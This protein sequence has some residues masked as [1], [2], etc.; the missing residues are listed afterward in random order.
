MERVDRIAAD[1]DAG[2]RA[3]EDGR[4][5]LSVCYLR[6]D[7]VCPS[8]ALRGR[9]FQ[10]CRAAKSRRIRRA[11]LASVEEQGARLLTQLRALQLQG[12]G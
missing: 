1:V 12:K 5:A 3:R 9:V 4:D 8:R 2:R 6:F 11:E 7:G 10:P